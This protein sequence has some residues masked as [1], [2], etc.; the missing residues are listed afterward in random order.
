MKTM[1]LIGLA[2]LALI[3]SRTLLVCEASTR[4]GALAMRRALAMALMLA[5]IVLVSVGGCTR[6][7]A[8]SAEEL[9]ALAA[10]CCAQYAGGAT[11]DAIRVLCTKGPDDVPFIEEI[12]RRVNVPR[13]GEGR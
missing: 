9:A 7:E 1:V 10:C 6:Q 2:F 13:D 4:R 12:I 5:A 3:L 11:A 8:R